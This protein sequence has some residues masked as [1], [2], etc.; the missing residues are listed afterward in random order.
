MAAEF[1]GLN[2]LHSHRNMPIVHR[3]VKPANILLDKRLQAKIG[4]FGI[5]RAFA[6]ESITHVSTLSKGTLGYLDPE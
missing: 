2:Y 1:L 3:D 5:S 6:T 4:D